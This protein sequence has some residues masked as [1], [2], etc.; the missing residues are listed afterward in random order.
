MIRELE[1]YYKRKHAE[2][3]EGTN[4]EA[5]SKKRGLRFQGSDSEAS[6]ARDT[7]LRDPCVV[8]RVRARRV[9]PTR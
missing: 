7:H 9:D 8:A 6:V 2:E 4:A 1:E 5:V 3:E